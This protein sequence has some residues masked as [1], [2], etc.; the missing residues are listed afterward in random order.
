M[1]WFLS[2]LL[3]FLILAGAAAGAAWIIGARLDT[4]FKGFAGDERFVDLAPGMSPQAIGRLLVDQGVV[5]DLLTFRVA[6]WR[7]GSARELKAGEY[8]FD[9]PVRPADVIARIARGDVFVRPLTFPEGLTIKEMAA[10]FEARGFG[11]AA[12]FAEAARERAL[13]ADLDDRADDLEGYLFPETYLLPRHASAERLVSLMVDRFRAVFVPALKEAAASRGLSVRQAVTLASI[14]EKETA[15]PD[16]RPIVAAV[17]L[18]R[19]KIRMGLQSDP[20]VIYALDKA[21]R[22][23]GNLTKD[24]LR[25]DSPYNSYRYA[26]LPPGPIAA[27]GL[28]SLEAAANPAD[29]DFLYFVSRNDGSHVF[30]RSLAEHNRNVQRYQPPF[31]SGKRASGRSATTVRPRR[32]P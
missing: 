28:S 22:Y 20:T 4:P 21:G 2:V 13:I 17:Y 3:I 12:S 32:V 25:F 24:N 16:E 18:H 15:K 19:L 1:R 7:S 23:H 30:A 9:R 26:G 27:P 6:L 5:R 8:R 10:I 14:V 31:Q 29:T 11:T